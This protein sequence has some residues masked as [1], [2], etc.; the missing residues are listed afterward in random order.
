MIYLHDSPINCHGHLKSSNCVVDSRWVLKITDYGLRE[1]R[2]ASDSPKLN[3]KTDE[4]SYYASQ[5]TPYAV[6]TG[7]KVILQYAESLSFYSPGGS[8]N[9]QLHVLAGGI[10]LQI[11]LFPGGSETLI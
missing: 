5:Y 1:F 2:N 4:R 10:R 6:I 8:S 9:F 7:T 11:S 3:C